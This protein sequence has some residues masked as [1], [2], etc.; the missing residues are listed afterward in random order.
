MAE[1]LGE[2]LL[3]GPRAGESVKTTLLP[4]TLAGERMGVRLDPPPLGAHSRE[5]LRSVG[6]ANAEIDALQDR[7]VV[8]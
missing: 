7:G 1:R 2:R 5:L 6:I 4:F 3:R 8:A